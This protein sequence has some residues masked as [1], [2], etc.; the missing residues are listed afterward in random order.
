MDKIKAVNPNIIVRGSVDKP[1][2]LI[3]YYDLSD[4]EWYIGYGSYCLANVKKWLKTY[5]EVTN[6]DVAPVK[7][8]EWEGRIHDRFYGTDE[9]GEPIYRDGVVYYCSECRHRSIIKTNFCPNCGTIM[10]GKDEKNDS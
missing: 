6:A 8:G 7:H 2:Y 4:N 9:D 1:Y 3:E 10:D 5:F